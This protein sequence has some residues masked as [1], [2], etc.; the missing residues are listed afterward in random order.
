[1][2]PNTLKKP[3]APV[4]SMSADPHHYHLV[5]NTGKLGYQEAAKIIVDAGSRHCATR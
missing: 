1:M 4:S 2:R 5:V 3:I